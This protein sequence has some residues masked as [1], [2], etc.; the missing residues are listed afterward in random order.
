MTQEGL[1]RTDSVDWFFDLI[2]ARHT[3]ADIGQC[4]PFE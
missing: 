3:D 1:Q 4:V 2:N